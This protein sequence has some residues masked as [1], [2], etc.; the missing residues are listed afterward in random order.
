M[1]PPIIPAPRGNPCELDLMLT[2]ES[3]DNYKRSD[4]RTYLKCLD[5][6]AD[7]GWQQFHCNNCRAYV[8]VVVGPEE[9]ALV[10]RLSMYFRGDE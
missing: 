10:A 9:R 4:C 5:M 2:S 3:V 6:A 7:E 1:L 8:A